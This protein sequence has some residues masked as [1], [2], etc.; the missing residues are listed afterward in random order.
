ME[1]RL[2]AIM[3]GLKIPNDKMTLVATAGGETVG[4]YSH[5]GQDESGIRSWLTQVLTLDPA[6]RPADALL[7]ELRRSCQF[8]QKFGKISLVFGCIGTDFCK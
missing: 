2:R 7:L 4:L 5:M 8:W 1:P 6:T 3:E